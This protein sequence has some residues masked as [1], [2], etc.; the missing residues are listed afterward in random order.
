MG[1][2]ARD[3]AEVGGGGEG[4]GGKKGEGEGEGE[5]GYTAGSCGKGLPARSR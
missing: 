4:G 2:R 5:K 3:A 1:E